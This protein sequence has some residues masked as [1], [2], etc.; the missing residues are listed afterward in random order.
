M[1]AKKKEIRVNILAGGED[2]KDKLHGCHNTHA[3][4]YLRRQIR[5]KDSQNDDESQTRAKEIIIR[6]DLSVKTPVIY[7]LI[8][9]C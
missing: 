7:T 3:D 6:W 8:G 2:L 4:F 9:L 1:K 5:K